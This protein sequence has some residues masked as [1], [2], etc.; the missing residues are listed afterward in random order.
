MRRL[1]TLPGVKIAA[2]KLA[3]RPSFPLDVLA[4]AESRKALV[5]HLNWFYREAVQLEA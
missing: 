5:E 4:A 1:N 3:L 2:A